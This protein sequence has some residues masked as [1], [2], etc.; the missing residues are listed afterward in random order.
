M[1]TAALAVAPALAPALGREDLADPLE[2]LP[3]S[4]PAVLAVRAERSDD[5]F[6]VGP[7]GTLT[8]GEA[9][10]RS[11]VLAGR[12]LAAGVGKGTRVGLL[13]PNGAGWAVGWLAA[14]RIG[15]LTVPLSTFAPGGE[16]AR[17]LRQTD[18]HA[19]LTA[20]H[21]AGDSLGDRVEAGLPD[22]VGSKPGLAIADAPFLRWIHVEQEDRSWSR[23]LP[24][25]L[26]LAMV[27][28]AQR[29]VGPADP[30]AII[31]TSGATAAPKATVHTH[32]SLVR[33]AALLAARRGLTSEDRIYSP[34][35]FFWVGGLTMVLLAAL[36]SGA[37][38]VVHERFE[39]GEAL[40]LIERE[41]VTQVSCWPNAARAM[42]E[43]P[44]FATRDLRCVR[45]GTLVEA[46]P[47]RSRPASPD[48]APIP[49]GMTET[50]GPHTGPDDA[51]APLP[52]S[53]RG[54]FGRTLPGMEHRIVDGEIHVRGRFLMDGIYKQERHRTFDP[55]G[56][57]A[58][59]DLG[60]FGA[61]GHLR[62][63]G[64]RTAMIK[65]GGS[66][67]S[68]AEV[69]TALVAM[70]QV[71]AAFV[72]GIAAGDRGEAVAAVVV[73]EPGRRVD[74]SDLSSSLR[75]S[76]SSY[77]VPR[78]YRVVAE[79]DLPMLPTGKADLVALR[80]LFADQRDSS[81]G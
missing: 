70:P 26:P 23:A 58:T 50:G 60:W 74:P 17:A 35:P 52:D 5:P 4:I 56:W 57:Y 21:F 43:H 34:M 44:S 76:L 20:S 36:T 7:D 62:F 41:R 79:P 77:K 47:P 1:A 15:A 69:E 55:D 53:L 31:S 59:G 45:G 3:D 32:G 54:T 37:A 65:T 63:A 75:T 72:F 12:L 30:L 66:N 25:P 24:R 38:A 64:R 48:L 19:L 2:G 22:L 9:C 29:E 49:L 11:A 13:H 33:H 40:D 51:Y 61:D 81:G 16:L 39:P 10:R 6:V 78:H 14:A 67:V 18:V 71:R 27:Q 80:A 73:P 68:P 42:G 46:L 8:F 28:A